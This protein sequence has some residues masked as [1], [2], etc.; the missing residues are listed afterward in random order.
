VPDED[1]LFEVGDSGGTAVQ[2]NLTE[3]M[4]HGSRRGVQPLSVQRQADHR[5]I[6]LGTR[7]EHRLDVEVGERDSEDLANRGLPGHRLKSIGFGTLGG[8]EH[9]RCDHESGVGRVVVEPPEHSLR[10]QAQSQLLDKLTAGRAG[11][12]LPAI[13]SPTR[14]HESPPVRVP[15]VGSPN[16]QHRKAAGAGDDGDGNRGPL[17]PPSPDATAAQA[18]QRI[19]DLLRRAHPGPATAMIFSSGSES[20]TIP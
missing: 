10:W 16:E 8:P 19:P 14:E 20:G 5:V 12:G 13:G 7:H 4:Q 9:Y 2:D 1:G 11:C 15:Q 3:L 18:P 6:G 17:K